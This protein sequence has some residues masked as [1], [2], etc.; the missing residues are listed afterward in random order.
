MQLVI[1]APTP[2]VFTL[3]AIEV[4]AWMNHYIAPFYVEKFSGLN[5]N[6]G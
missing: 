4:M 5:L 3:T 6:N 1:H 2:R